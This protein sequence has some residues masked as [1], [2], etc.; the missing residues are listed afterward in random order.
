LTNLLA[1]QLIDRH[2]LSASD[3]LSTLAPEIKLDYDPNHWFP[4]VKVE[5]LMT[6]SSGLPS[7]FELLT[8]GTTNDE[9]L[10][11][12][13][14]SA[15]FASNDYVQFEPGKI[16]FG[17]NS[18]PKL[19][20]IAT[21]KTSGVR[22]RTAVKQSILVPLGMNRTYYKWIDANV[23]G[24]IATTAPPIYVADK[25]EDAPLAGPYS[26]VIDAAKVLVFYL[27]GNA[28]ILSEQTRLNTLSPKTGSSLYQDRCRVGWA[29]YVQ[30]G[31]CWGQDYYDLG[32]RLVQTDVSFLGV[33]TLLLMVPDKKFAIAL[34]ANQ[35][36][37]ELPVLASALSLIGVQKA[38][39]Q[40]VVDT[41]DLSAF[42]RYEGTYYTQAPWPEP[43]IRIT[44]SN[45]ILHMKWT[46]HGIT[47]DCDLVPTYPRFFTCSVPYPD[48]DIPRAG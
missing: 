27:N 16:V 41:P 44:L 6:W 2:Q 33:S 30:D 24:N 8:S 36:W 5:D 17:S 19:L 28:S 10:Q 22:F 39:W 7:D 32:V 42:D 47:N 23:D 35:A 1:T 48:P 46:A 11:Q 20:A 9:G 29:W 18:E 34:M 37:N 3:K 21:E 26:S 12:W 38:A 45:R 25:T 4:Q 13:A 14:T 31:L 43:A 40:P 15:A